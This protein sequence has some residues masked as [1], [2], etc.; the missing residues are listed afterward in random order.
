MQPERNAPPVVNLQVA[1]TCN[2]RCTFCSHDRW[3]EPTGFMTRAV[4]D[5]AIERLKDDGCTTVC[6]VSAQ[7]ES[8]LHP[9]IFAML[10]ASL[11]A[12]FQTNIVTNGTPLNERRIQRLA[13]LDLHAIQF[14]FA[15]WDKA[16]YERLYVGGKFEQVTRNLVALSAALEH[17]RAVLTINGVVD[18]VD[19]ISKTIGFLMGL[20][21]S[22][23]RI[24]VGLPHNW[25][26][27][28]RA[29]DEQ[30]GIYSHRVIDRRSFKVCPLLKSTQG[31]YVDG[32]VTACG[33]ID[34]NGDLEIGHIR[35]SGI[36]SMRAGS[37][38]QDLLGAFARAEVGHVPLCAGC[39][40]PYH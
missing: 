8:L 35:D 5:L 6:F 21:L 24:S 22:R 36:A 27:T 14:S 2:L 25:G 32:R 37:R 20:G 15:G 33:C 16:S 11:A 7:G 29:G 12:G 1:R 9:D 38:Y 17:R 10:E 39:E 3:R 30:S 13:A 4:F 28:V 19:G 34:A 26:G 31:I 40:I 23:H 18:D